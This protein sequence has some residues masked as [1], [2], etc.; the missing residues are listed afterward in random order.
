MTTRCCVTSID[1]GR[2]FVLAACHKYSLPSPSK[3]LQSTYFIAYG[4][5]TGDPYDGYIEMCLSSTAASGNT[6]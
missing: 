1:F 6:K 4:A 2:N 3:M 5:F